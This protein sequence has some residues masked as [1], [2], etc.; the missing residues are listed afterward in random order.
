M[1][2][3]SCC[4]AELKVS[5]GSEGTGCY[6]CA[7][8]GKPCDAKEEKMSKRSESIVYDRDRLEAENAQL[9]AEINR[10]RSEK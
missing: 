9:K 3:S 6:L 7:K 5:Y 10:L 1:T 2:R 4:S 8:C